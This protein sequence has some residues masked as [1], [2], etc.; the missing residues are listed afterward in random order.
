MSNSGTICVCIS[1]PVNSIIKIYDINLNE[2]SCC[3]FD[4]YIRCMSIFEWYNGREMLAVGLRNKKIEL[5]KIPSFKHLWTLNGFNASF[6]EVAN[7]PIKALFIGTLEGKVLKI[8][9]ED[10]NETSIPSDLSSSVNQILNI[11]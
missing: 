7:S 4:S 3:V 11:L 6:I 2:I 5:I 8:D 1:R 10:I 9:I